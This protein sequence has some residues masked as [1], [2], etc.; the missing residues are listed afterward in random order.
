MSGIR[1]A[2]KEIIKTVEQLGMLPLLTASNILRKESNGD[3]VYLNPGM[4]S[5]LADIRSE[6]D[7]TDA[8][9]VDELLEFHSDL[10]CSSA[11]TSEECYSIDLSDIAASSAQLA[12]TNVNDEEVDDDHPKHCHFFHE[13][14]CKYIEPN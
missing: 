7:E 13:G 4:E 3:I 12:K 8:V 9:T 6:P 5:T 2:E 1:E 11:E 10:L 14:R